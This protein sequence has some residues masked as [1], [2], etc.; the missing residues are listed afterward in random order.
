MLFPGL[1]FGLHLMRLVLAEICDDWEIHTLKIIRVKIFCG[2]KFSWFR[3]IRE[4]FLTVDGYNRDK[5]FE[6]SWHLVYYDISSSL[7]PWLPVFIHG[8][9][10]GYEASIGRARYHQL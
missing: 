10:P 7:V 9:E 5:H 8:E 2:V 1:H 4:I 6:C 3:S